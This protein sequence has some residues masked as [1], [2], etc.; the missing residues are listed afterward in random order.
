M[1][2]LVHIIGHKGIL[3]SAMS[4][5]FTRKYDYILHDRIDPTDPELPG[6]MEG[7]WVINCAGA[8]KPTIDKEG[9]EYAVEVNTLLPQLLS[10]YCE[11]NKL[12]LICFSSDCVY[13][14]TREITRGGYVESDKPDA[15][16]VYAIS[17]TLGEP[18]YGMTLRTSFIGHEDERDNP[19]GML[20]WLLNSTGA[21]DGYT[22]CYW[23]G[24]TAYQ[25]AKIV[26]AI[27]TDRLYDYGLYHIH[28]PSTVTKY[29]VCNMVNEAYNLDLTVNPK[30]ATSIMCTEI[31]ND[32]NRTLA[33]EFDFCKLLDIPEIQE[34]IKEQK[35]WQEW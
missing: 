15:T 1:K 31:D 14:G 7:D 3:G 8:L 35:I 24:V 20:G 2:P 23:N 10:Q 30:K 11:W 4:K 19:R 21:V 28:S 13:T 12:R 32:L 34:Q 18:P 6:H 25:L 22:N 5:Y 26:D 9:D 16:D 17:K 27:I 33:S 29:E